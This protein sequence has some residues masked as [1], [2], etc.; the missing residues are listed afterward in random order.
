MTSVFAH[1]HA[2]PSALATRSLEHSARRHRIAGIHSVLGTGHTFHLPTRHEA[3]TLRR[4]AIQAR[5]TLLA[6]LAG[7]HPAREILDRHRPGRPFAKVHRSCEVRRA[8]RLYI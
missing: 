5:M 3:H 6:L 1:T 8:A 2:I 7:E 4:H